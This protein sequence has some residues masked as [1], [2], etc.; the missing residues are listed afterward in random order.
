MIWPFASAIAGPVAAAITS[1]GV[2][3]GSWTPAALY[4]GGYALGSWEVYD[5]S[6]LWQDT[7][8]TSPVTATGQAVKRIDDI[9]GNGNHV[10]NPTGWVL[11][12][13]AFGCMYL[14]TDGVSAFEA[15][16][17]AQTSYPLTLCAAAKSDV[18]TNAL[19]II[20]L[21][22]SDSSYKS[23]YNLSATGWA[24][25]DR[26][27]AQNA[28][29]EHIGSNATS[30]VGVGEFNTSSANLI[31][32]GVDA[33]AATANAN[34]FGALDKVYI[35]KT[36]SAGN[37]YSG[38]FYGANAINK[39]LSLAERKRLENFRAIKSGRQYDVLNGYIAEGDSI[40]QGYS[41]TGQ[42]GYAQ[43]LATMAPRLPVNFIQA[44][45]GNT[46]SDVEARLATTSANCASIIANGM[47]PIVFMMVGMNDKN[48]ITSD[49]AAYFA[50]ITAYAATVRSYGAK[51]IACTVTAS[52]PVQYAS[53][54]STGRPAL[55]AL[56]RAGNANF[57]AVCDFAGDSRLN[58]WGATY[59]ADGQH[60]NDA[61]HSI[62]RDVLISAIAPIRRSSI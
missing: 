51:F 3:G 45:S 39:T 15:T 62:M 21:R 30:H 19:N 29:A 25:N 5:I 27:A 9:S 61:G 8:G 16:V 14:Q 20:S 36:F 2:G 44:V 38:R 35:G 55:N 26:N 41:A 52:D 1:P 42:V 54:E 57:D 43:Q 53:F 22:A 49:A 56:I 31:M 48:A 33:S 47:Q 17:T 11:A 10:T 28:N 46:M 12:E 6:K 59:F 40:T 4:A 24:V 18:A 34:A 7:A 32:D 23:L 50:R 58:V 60:P 37:Y 13:D